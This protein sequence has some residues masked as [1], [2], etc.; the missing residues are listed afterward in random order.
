MKIGVVVNPAA[1]GG[2]LREL[3]PTIM[4][5]FEQRLERLSVVFTE[6]PGHG[7]DLAEGLARG[8]ADLIIAA[9]GDGTA[10]EVADGILRS[11][12][13]VQ[14]G[15]V[16]VGTGRD[17]VRNF[18]LQRGEMAAVEAIC[19]GRTRAI[20]VG[21]AT[22][23]ADDGGTAVRHFINVASLG[24]SGPTVRAVNRAKA[25][26]PVSARLAF[27]YHTLRELMAYRVQRVSVVTDGGAAFEFDTALVAIANGRFF[28]G[29]M[30]VAPGASLEDGMFDVLLYR[31]QGKL[32][33]LLDFQ[34]IYKGLHTTLPRVTIIRARQVE[35]LPAKGSADNAAILDIDGESPG[36]IAARFEVLPKALI[37]RV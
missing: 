25:N 16:P 36:R 11:R 6:K 26:R 14:L 30:M 28:G 21:R 20:D 31:P 19:S 15:I 2:R 17:F 1:G 4:S 5:A 29:G 13:S 32:R 22:Y 34:L 3:W 33:M 23:V 37:L 12:M 8:G 10:S 18:G 24:V 7:V 27:Y 35:V 9:G